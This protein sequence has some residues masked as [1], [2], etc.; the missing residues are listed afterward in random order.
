[1]SKKIGLALGSGG[2][3]GPAHVGVIKSLVKNNIPIDYISGSSIGSL[4]GAHYALYQDIEKLEKD[5]LNGWKDKYQIVMDLS[6]KG[7]I[8][9]GK[10]VEQYFQKL[11]NNK[12][13]SDTKIPLKI[14]STDL[15][16]GE[17]VIITKG[18]LGSAVRASS[19]IPLTF[20]PVDLKNSKLIDGA[21]TNPIPAEVLSHMGSDIKIGVNLYNHYNFKN[22]K[23]KIMKIT[24]RALE[25]MLYQLSKL[26]R[27]ECDIFIE[28]NTSQFEDIPRWKKYI[29]NKVIIKLIQAGEEAMDAQIPALKKLL[30]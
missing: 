21:I 25:I 20:R 11:L 28:P 1:M 27:S 2:F 26:S 30:N 4:V 3:R 16:S 15:I 18:D 23:P 5:F 12:K 13:F 14:T 9:S 17:S 22:K 24:M 8:L 6:Y 7:G 29:D 19:S 10:K